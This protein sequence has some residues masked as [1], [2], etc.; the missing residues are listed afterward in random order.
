ME[1]EIIYIVLKQH[2]DKNMIHKL[3]IYMDYTN[4][5]CQLNVK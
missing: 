1:Y 3:Y 5:Q 4:F 2:T